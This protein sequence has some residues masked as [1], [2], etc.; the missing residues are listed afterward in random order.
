MTDSALH[1][2]GLWITVTS[3]ILGAVNLVVLWVVEFHGAA[4]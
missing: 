1:R 4:L 2:V 3:L